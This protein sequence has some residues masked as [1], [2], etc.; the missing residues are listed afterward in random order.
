MVKCQENTWGLLETLPHDMTYRH[1]VGRQN[2]HAYIFNHSVAFVS[3]NQEPSLR[4]VAE[5]PQ[6]RESNIPFKSL[7]E[8]SLPSKLILGRQKLI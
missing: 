2:S 4:M 3:C 5:H 7:H 1:A 6:G 8:V